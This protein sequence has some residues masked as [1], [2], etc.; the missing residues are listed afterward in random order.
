MK[1]IVMPYFAMGP[2]SSMKFRSKEF[3][4]CVKHAV[5]SVVEAFFLA[6]IGHND[7]HSANVLLKKTSLK[8]IEYN[9]FPNE[10][11][12]FEIETN[13]GLMDFEKSARIDSQSSMRDRDWFL[14]DLKKFFLMMP[15]LC[16]EKDIAPSDVQGIVSYIGTIPID[17][18]IRRADVDGILRTIDE[19]FCF[20]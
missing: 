7:F 13:G 11:E 20:S 18:S 8:T 1:V 9:P 10:D 3:A 4:S 17:R 2:L 12:S 19:A 14:Y 16:R 6:G 5:M 15:T